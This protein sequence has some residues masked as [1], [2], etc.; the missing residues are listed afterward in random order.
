[1]RNSLAV[2]IVLSGLFGLDAC[3][4]GYAQ[5]GKPATPSVITEDSVN[6]SGQIFLTDFVSANPEIRSN[7]RL[8]LLGVMD[9]TE[10]KSW[11]DY[12]T[13]KTASLDEFVFESLKKLTPEQ[14][15]RRAAVLIEEALHKTFPCKGTR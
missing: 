14:L 7:A 11:C 15:N 12:K 4:Y 5:E 10:G 2:S 13:L 8:Y 1:M 9:A 3:G 6:L